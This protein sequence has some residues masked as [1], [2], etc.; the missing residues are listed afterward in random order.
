MT[1]Y[2]ARLKLNRSDFPANMT[3]EEG[4]VMQKH[5]AFLAEQLARGVLVVAGPV[6]DP[7]GVFG[8]GVFEADSIDTVQS[9]LAGDPV[10]AIGRYEVVPMGPVVVRGK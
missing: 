1:H 6:F 4:E 9:L 7:A 3:P 2:L 8:L 5:G 10:T